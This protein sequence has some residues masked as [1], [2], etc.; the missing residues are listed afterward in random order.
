M[1]LNPAAGNRVRKSKRDIF[2]VVLQRLLTLR[3]PEPVKAQLMVLD[4]EDRIR[5]APPRTEDGLSCIKGELRYQRVK[6]RTGWKLVSHA[7]GEDEETFRS[8]LLPKVSVTF[9]LVLRVYLRI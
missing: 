8:L 7:D 5:S 3:G 9:A 1:F 4:P 2:K 6:L